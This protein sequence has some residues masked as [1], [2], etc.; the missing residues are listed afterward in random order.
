MKKQVKIVDYAEHIG[1]RLVRVG[2]WYSL[3]EHD[4]IRIDPEKNLFYRNSTGEAGSI[5]DFII[6][7]SGKD[8]KGAIKELENFSGE[9]KSVLAS[10]LMHE[11]SNAKGLELSLPPKSKDNKNVYAYLIKTRGIDK[12][13]V[14]WM[15]Q[16]RYLYQDIFKNCVF[17][18]YKDNVPVFASLRGTNTYRRF[19]ADI[20]GSDYTHGLL[21]T[22]EKKEETLIITESS[23]DA[24][25]L[26]TLGK[27]GDFLAL[28]GVNKTEPVI[29]HLSKGVYKNIVLALDNDA[30]G[31]TAIEKI[32]KEVL[33]KGLLLEENITILIPSEKDWNE[34]LLR[35]K[36]N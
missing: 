10:C 7:F 11:E 9:H 4:S 26:M 18:S 21:F 14:N 3:K 5:I 1:F 17:V 36:E 6:A 29:N 2:R 35:G 20:S 33:E 13:V 28:S 19:L 23:I 12:E 15:F 22:G 32:K 31:R 25:S 16:K 30:A 24:M 34:D 27:K 8:L